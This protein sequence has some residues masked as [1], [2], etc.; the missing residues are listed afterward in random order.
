MTIT[1]PPENRAFATLNR[2]NDLFAMSST[3]SIFYCSF[4]TIFNH[5]IFTPSVNP[6][7][8]SGNHL[9]IAVYTFILVI[10]R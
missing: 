10:S 6:A 8:P 9:G 5:A 2:A 1:P 7:K 3:L 4:L